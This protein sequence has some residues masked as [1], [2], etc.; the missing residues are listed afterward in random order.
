MYFGGGCVK[1]YIASDEKNLK[2]V[3]SLIKKLTSKGFTCVN[4]GN[5]IADDETNQITDGIG[6]YEKKGIEEADFMLIFLTAGKGNLY[7][8]GYALSLNKKIIVYSP[9]KDNYHI[10]KKSIFHNLPEV[11]I[12][13]GT[14]YKLV[15]LI[16]TLSPEGSEKN[17]SLPLK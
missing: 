14:F 8:L 3:R 6:E 1:Y 12:C 4:G 2:Q 15:K 11:T 9:E 17:D 7:E 13:S 10:N 5:L 16:H